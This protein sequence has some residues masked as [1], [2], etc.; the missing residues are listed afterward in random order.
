MK[1]AC[2]LIAVGALA[3]L[4]PSMPLQAEVSAE[5]DAFGNYLR[6]VIFTTASVKSNLRIWAINRVKLNYHPLNP[7]GD[8]TGDLF[9]LVA[10]NAAQQ[11][12]PWVVWSRF[13]GHDYDLVWS[14]WM[15]TAWS[16]V[17]T[18]EPGPGPDDAVDPAIA[19]DAGGRTH[20]VWLSRGTG[21]AQV[22]L[23]I[24][25]STH[26]MMPFRVSDTTDD[27]FAPS[28]TVL[29]DGTIQV[30]YDTARGTVTKL[31]KFAKPRTITDDITPFNTLS[32]TATYAP[33]LVP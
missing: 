20:M 16:P 29:P 6:T 8:L 9:P 17:S 30:T 2:R 3:L 26:W 27:A 13:N 32:I 10:E 1:T 7:A 24:F 21:A 12:W 5:T 11:R 28:I 23:S 33:S 22:N 18:I 14:R 25:L 4:A 15:G 19:F 31:I